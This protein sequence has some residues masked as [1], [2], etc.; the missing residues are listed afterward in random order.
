[1]YLKSVIGVLRM[2]LHLQSCLSESYDII[3]N[4]SFNEIGNMSQEV[5]HFQCQLWCSIPV[6]L[7]LSE[8]MQEDQRFRLL[9]VLS[10]IA[11][12]RS[13]WAT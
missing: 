11:R 2:V 1:M 13:A 4:L 9:K 5:T 6:I 8:W 7:A 12:L 3:C 10:Y